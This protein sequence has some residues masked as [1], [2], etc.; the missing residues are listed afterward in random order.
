LAV[1]SRGFEAD[2]VHEGVEII[3][4]PLAEAIELRSSL[5]VDADIAAHGGQ[6]TGGEWR[7]D[8]VEQLWKDETD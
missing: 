7:I 3:H 4:D 6:K 1:L 5:L 8:A 2:G